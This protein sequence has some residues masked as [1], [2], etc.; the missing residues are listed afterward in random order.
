M[1][2]TGSN[3]RCVP[4]FS[5]RG[6]GRAREVESR[7]TSTWGSHDIWESAV[8]SFKPPRLLLELS[9]EFAGTLILIM[10]GVGVTTQVVAAQIGNH[11]SIAWA[12]GFGVTLGVYTAARI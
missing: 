5:A 9:A 11:D 2:T 10:F 8:T 12:W 4:H 6:D 1:W 7:S 3:V